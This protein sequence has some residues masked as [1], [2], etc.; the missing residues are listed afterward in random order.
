MPIKHGA[1]DNENSMSQQFRRD[2]CAKWLLLLSSFLY[3]KM[4]CE[5]VY[6][7]LDIVS[8]HTV[9]IKKSF[10]SEIPEFSNVSNSHRLLGPFATE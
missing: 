2:F 5:V 6:V 7:L 3:C 8:I 4:M 1:F 9:L 10:F